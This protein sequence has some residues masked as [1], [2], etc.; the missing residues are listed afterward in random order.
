MRHS[1]H[2][3]L[4]HPCGCRGGHAGRCGDC[5]SGW[6]IGQGFQDLLRGH[7]GRQCRA[8]NCQR[9]GVRRGLRPRHARPAG[10]SDGVT[11]GIEED[12][13]TACCRLYR[14]AASQQELGCRECQRPSHGLLSRRA[15]RQRDCRGA[16]WRLQ[17]IRTIA[18]VCA[19][20]CGTTARLLQ[21]ARTSSP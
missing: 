17:S 1:R 20:P 21:Q 2:D 5:R 8:A 13:Q 14:G 16:L 11:R 19:S 12:W 3:G 15:R 9:H 6:I 18:H 4:R 10:P 7:G